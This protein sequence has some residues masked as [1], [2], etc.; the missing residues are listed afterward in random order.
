MKTWNRM[1]VVTLG[2]V[3]GASTVGCNRLGGGGRTPST[4]D[5]KTL[6][7]LGMILGRNLGTFNL[8]PD[9]L[10][11][12]ESGLADMVLKKEHKV[13]LDKYGPKVDALARKR[14]QERVAVE[15]AQ[16]KAFLDKAAKEPGAVVTPSGMVFRT[17]TPGTGEVPKPTD[18]VSVQYEGRLTDGT[19]FDSTKKRGGVP[20][21]FPLNGVIKCWT[22]GVGRMHVGEKAELTCPSTI[23]YGD[24]GRPPTIPG[25][26]TLI[27]DVELV[28]IPPANN[29]GSTM[30][31]G[32]GGGAGP[33]GGPGKPGMPPQMHMMGGPGGQ[34][35]MMLT[36]PGGKPAAGQ[37]PATAGSSK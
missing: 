32:P 6:Y 26:A 12:V 29:I 24:S 2:V 13:D 28:S 17:I 31:P 33:G 22:E 21:T 7:A 16:S 25:G 36:P 3:V 19:V 23:A 9:E 30:P 27:F 10:Q 4:E 1:L 35:K 34:Q 8:K 15:K 20:A 5:E 37:K 11:M 18:R 14:G